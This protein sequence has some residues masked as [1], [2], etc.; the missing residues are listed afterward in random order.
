VATLGLVLAVEPK[1]PD[2]MRRPPRDPEAPILSRVLLW[3][4]LLVGALILIGAFGLFEWELATGASVEQARTVAVNA[5]IMIEIFYLLNCRSLSQSMFQI[6]LW[7]N[8]WVMVGIA[9]M[10][11]LQLAF[12]Y[13]PVMNW[14]F[15]SAPIDAAFWVR[16]VAVGIASY[17]IVE[18]DKWLR[19]RRAVLL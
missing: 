7:T 15:A 19:R 5:V 6:G 9:V 1:E 10:V 2:I 4:I 18:L 13:L 17:L 11:V 12:T 14:L 8:R 16:I 3:R